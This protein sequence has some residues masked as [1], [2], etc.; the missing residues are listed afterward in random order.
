MNANIK[1]KIAKNKIAERRE[2]WGSIVV[3]I[4]LA[5]FIYLYFS[6]AI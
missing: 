2:F 1:C 6:F 5:I 4:G 3:G